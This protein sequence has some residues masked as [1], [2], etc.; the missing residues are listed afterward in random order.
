MKLNTIIFGADDGAITVHN[1]NGGFARVYAA[2]L[3][4]DEIGMELAEAVLFTGATARDDF[5]NSSSIDYCDEEGFEDGEAI[6]FVTSAM[7]FLSNK[8]ET[9]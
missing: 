7:E 8:L 4:F 1:S 3:R 2:G 9:L 6:E 5:F